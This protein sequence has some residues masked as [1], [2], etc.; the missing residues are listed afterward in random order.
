MLLI[1]EPSF[2]LTGIVC[3]CYEDLHFDSK[4]FTLDK[5]GLP[6]DLFT[7]PRTQIPYTIRQLR[8]RLKEKGR[9]GYEIIDESLIKR[10]T[11]IE[12]IRKAGVLNTAVLDEVAKNIRPGMR[13]SEIDDIVREFT[14]AHGGIW[15]LPFTD[16]LFSTNLSLFPSFTNGFYTCTGTD[17]EDETV[18]VS[19][20]LGNSPRY[21]PRVMNPP[22]IAVI[23]LTKEAV[24]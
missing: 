23:T 4:W 22:Q 6:D 15:R 2:F 18:F 9:K 7:D 10:P 1:W 19:R 20:G 21:L 3:D 16:G 13:T 17:C 24:Q 5:A 12:G 14:H 11:M 8:S